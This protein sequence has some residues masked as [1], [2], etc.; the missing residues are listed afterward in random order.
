MAGYPLHEKAVKYA[1]NE[2]QKGVHEIPPHSN[3]GPRVEHYQSFDFLVGGGYPWCVDFWLASWV[4]GAGYNLPY[5]GAGA[6]NY[7]DWARKHGW[8]VPIQDAVPGDAVVLNIGSG[9]MAMYLNFEGHNEIK[10]VN[11]N[12]SDRVKISNYTT[13]LIR[14]FVHVPEKHSLPPQKPPLFIVTTSINGH[15]K[16]ILTQ[17]TWKRLAPLLPNIVKNRGWNGFTIKRVR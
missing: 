15:R 10:T 5:R 9:H 14:G 13:G 7:L 1:L 2:A 6:Y 4:E 12:V 3:R 17:R 11:G 8:A 16:V